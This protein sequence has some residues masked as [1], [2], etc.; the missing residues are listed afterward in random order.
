M[1]TL[2]AVLSAMLLAIIAYFAYAL[3]QWLGIVAF[4]CPY[5]IFCVI[6]ALLFWAIWFS[7]LKK[8]ALVVGLAVFTVLA[9][10]FLLPPPSERLLRSVLLGI[11]PGTAV[12]SIEKIVEE[13]YEG[14]GYVLPAI[15][16]EDA[17]VHVSLLSQQSGNCTALIFT[18]ENGVVISGEFSAD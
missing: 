16:R 9:A 13:E 6:A 11:P 1:K 17:R 2:L 3:D 4:T 18:A 8:R 15:T 7:I 10:N 14:S 5:S 12:G